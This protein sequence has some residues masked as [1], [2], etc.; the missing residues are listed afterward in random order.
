MW[1]ILLGSDL[2]SI[3]SVILKSKAVGGGLA[4]SFQAEISITSVSIE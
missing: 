2:T 4:P 1:P 3:L